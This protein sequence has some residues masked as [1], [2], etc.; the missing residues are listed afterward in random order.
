MSRW[1]LPKISFEFCTSQKW[2]TREEPK[3]REI[4]QIKIV[5]YLKR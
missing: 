2:D 1:Y 5:Y 3:I 4:L